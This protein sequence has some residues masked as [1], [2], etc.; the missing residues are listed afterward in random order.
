MA[1][2]DSTL[3][4][5]LQDPTVVDDLCYAAL[6]AS[7]LPWLLIWDNAESPA[8]ADGFLPA[9]RGLARGRIV[10]TTRSDGATWP[11]AAVAPVAIGSLAEDEAV[12]LLVC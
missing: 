2:R 6:D 1:V 4:Y 10:V 11:A 9:E 3:D 12:D 8:A 5:R 7:G